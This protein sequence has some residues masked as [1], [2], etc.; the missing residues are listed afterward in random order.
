VLLGPGHV[1]NARDF[2]RERMEQLRARVFEI[3]GIAR[4][5]C[6]VIDQG[7]CHNLLVQFV[8]EAWDS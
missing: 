5:H 3:S 6:Q 7:D 8:R 1:V 4:H 2:G